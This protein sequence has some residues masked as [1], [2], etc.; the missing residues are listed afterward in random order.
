MPFSS[1]NFKISIHIYSQ[2]NIIPQYIS[3]LCTTVI[4]FLKIKH[5]WIILGCYD[6][7]RFSASLIWPTHLSKT[8]WCSQYMDQEKCCYHCR[9]RSK[10]SAKKW[11]EMGF[12]EN[13]LPMTHSLLP[14]LTH[15]QFLQN[16]RKWCSQ[17]FVKIWAGGEHFKLKL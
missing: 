9:P 16:F 3:Y 13:L 11:P 10:E 6:F 15:T 14:F 1:I 8:S 5:E 4:Q 12:C 2:Q 17:L 7:G